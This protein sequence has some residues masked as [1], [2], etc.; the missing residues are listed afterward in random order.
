MW[1]AAKLAYQGKLI[2][3]VVNAKAGLKK[4]LIY[5]YSGTK[6]APISTD[7]G[8]RHLPHEDEPRKV[9]LRSGRR[10]PRIKCGRRI[11]NRS[12]STAA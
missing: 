12:S 4:R 6:D 10:R 9:S 3:A 2:A 11:P 8:L 5:T 7:H 1:W